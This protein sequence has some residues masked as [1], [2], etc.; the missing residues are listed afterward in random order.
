M[1]LTARRLI[2]LSI[3]PVSNFKSSSCSAINFSVYGIHFNL[4]CLTFKTFSDWS[5]AFDYVCKPA[6]CSERFWNQGQVNLILIPILYFFPSRYAATHL[7]IDYVVW[8]L[9]WKIISMLKP[10]LGNEWAVPPPLFV[11]KQLIVQNGS[12]VHVL[13]LMWMR[14]H[15]ILHLYLSV[16]FPRVSIETT[17][18]ES[19]IYFW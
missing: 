1:S 18:H 9:I 13:S 11:I 15:G 19:N 14:L 2:L 4:Q 17:W 6:I 5:N 10:N 7:W 3:S 8:N 12:N 16:I